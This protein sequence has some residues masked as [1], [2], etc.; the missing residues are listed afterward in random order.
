MA[1]ENAKRRRNSPESTREE[2]VIVDLPTSIARSLLRGEQ[3]G[4]GVRDA[5]ETR[6]SGE[7]RGQQRIPL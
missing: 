2:I 6:G 3:K 4:K 7:K 5:E 1:R